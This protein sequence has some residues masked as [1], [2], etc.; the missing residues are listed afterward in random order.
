MTVKQEIV[1]LL[2]VCIDLSD[3]ATLKR[4][5]DS[6]VAVATETGCERLFVITAET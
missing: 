4:E 3:V 5:M 1:A 2:Q 6:L